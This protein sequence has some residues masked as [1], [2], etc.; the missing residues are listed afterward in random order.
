[1]DNKNAIKGGEF[2][3]RET[4]PEEIFIPEEFN[5]EQRMIAQ[6]CDDFLETEVIPNLDRLDNHEEGLMPEIL[7]KSRRTWLIGHINS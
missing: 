4:S 5:E 6:T 3:I 1:M 7:K 2:I